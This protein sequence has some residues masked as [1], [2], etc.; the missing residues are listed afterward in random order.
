MGDGK[1]M[2]KEGR[3]TSVASGFCC[4]EELN[5]RTENENEFYLVSASVKNIHLC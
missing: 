2:E 3:A 5:F 1:G 4:H